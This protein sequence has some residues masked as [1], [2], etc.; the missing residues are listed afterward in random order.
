[1][2]SKQVHQRAKK[3]QSRLLPCRYCG[4]TCV[5]LSAEYTQICVSDDRLYHRAQI[6]TVVE[7]WVQCT[8]K[9]CG[10]CLQSLSMDDVIRRWN[11]LQ[12]REG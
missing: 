3:N 2:P 12:N 5:V 9:G 8:R 4:E 7:W 11:D 1:M 6:K 10:A